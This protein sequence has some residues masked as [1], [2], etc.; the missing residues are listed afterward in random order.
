[1]YYGKAIGQLIKELRM[2]KAK[3]LLESS[4]DAVSKIAAQVGYSD[5][6]YFIRVFKKEIGMT[7]KQYALRCQ[8][9][10]I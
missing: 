10:N 9:E 2:D 4:N 8:R 3:Q 1:M 7:P 5:Y 6:N